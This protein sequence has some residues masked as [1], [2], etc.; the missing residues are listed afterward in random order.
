[1][2]ADD[3]ERQ[4]RSRTPELELRNTEALQQSEQ[5]RNCRAASSKPRTFEWRH[6]ARELHDSAGQIPVKS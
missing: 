5:L 6:F 2:L 3:V 4:V 1:M